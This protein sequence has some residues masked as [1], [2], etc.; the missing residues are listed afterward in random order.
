MSPARERLRL[1]SSVDLVVAG[2]MASGA[3]SAQPKPEG[4]HFQ[5]P[6]VSDPM[7]APPPPPARQ[8]KSWDEAL[9][10]LRAHSPD[11]ITSYQ[12]VVRAQAQSRI[13]LAAVLPTLTGQGSYTHQFLTETIAIGGLAFVSP[14]PDTFTAGAGLQWSVLNPRA[15]YAVGTARENAAATPLSFEDKRRAI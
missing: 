1:I 14:P 13:V 2:A 15:L 5:A 12:S 10:L 6:A 8:V 9:A 4:P 11:Y 7:L 3:A